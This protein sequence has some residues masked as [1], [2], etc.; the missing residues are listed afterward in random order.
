MRV[1]DPGHIYDMWQLGSDEAQRL[2]FI[3]RSGGAVQY[4]QE[5]PG[6]QV[7]EV[8]RVLIDRSRYLNDVIECAE[9]KDAIWY[10]QMALFAYESRAYRRKQESVNRESPEHDDT[11]RPRDWRELPLNDVPFNEQD[12][13]FRPIGKDGHIIVD[14]A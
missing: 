8:L 5:W 7:Q 11:A 3:K 14:T 6:V 10:M 9:T 12:I 13:D 4:E 1:V 2:T